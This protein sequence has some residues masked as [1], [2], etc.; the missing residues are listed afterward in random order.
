MIL[1]T[2]DV[3]DW[4]QVENLRR[5]FPHSTWDGCELRVEA[6]TQRVL[7]LLDEAGEGRSNH[8]AKG[9]V[10]GTFFVL[11]WIAERVPGLVREIVKR[12]HE[13][14]SH[15]YR[16]RLCRLEGPAELARDLERSRKLLEDLSGRAVAGYRAPGFSISDEVL[17]QVVASGYRYDSSFNSFAFNP[18]YGRLDLGQCRRRGIAYEVAPGFHELP[19]GNVEIRGQVLPWAGGGYFRLLP[20]RL[21]NLGVQHIL[22]GGRDYLFYLHPWEFDPGQPRVRELG[23]LS[24][25]RH[26][27][28]LERTAERFRR[29]IGA[30][31]QER[32]TTCSDYL[33]SVGT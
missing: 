28:N 30:F 29:F 22:D 26:Y 21:F 2:F 12:G 8:G 9:L 32:F 10:R 19:L 23:R 13:V 6:S 18:R 15:G 27:L 4:F 17:R 25:L 31:P 16:H 7:D 1:L 14:A 11:G 24:R 33:E 5:C 20:P 3:E